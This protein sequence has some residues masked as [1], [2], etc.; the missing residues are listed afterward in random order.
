MIVLAAAH[1]SAQAAHALSW[2]VIIIVL[3]AALRAV[4]WVLGV[5]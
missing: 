1:M 5:R 4:L 3:V 2:A